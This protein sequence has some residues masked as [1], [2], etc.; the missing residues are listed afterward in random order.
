MA[1]V[2]SCIYLFMSALVCVVTWWLYFAIDRSDKWVAT[3]H[4][5]LHSVYD[6]GHVIF[7]CLSSMR[8]KFVLLY[9]VI[10]GIIF[11][12]VHY[13]IMLNI[14]CVSFISLLLH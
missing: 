10:D 9:T 14:T 8:I 2:S 5:I 12:I 6:L 1:I 4:G 13:S 7:L 3:T 11:A